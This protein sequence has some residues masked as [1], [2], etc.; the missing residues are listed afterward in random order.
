M[1]KSAIL[2]DGMNL[3]YRHYHVKKNDKN[4]Y[5]NGRFVGMFEGFL[6]TLKF[7][8]KRHHGYEIYVLWDSKTRKRLV[9]HP[10]YKKK[11]FKTEEDEAEKKKERD[12][13]YRLT[14]DLK[15]ILE[16]DGVG[17]LYAEGYEADDLAGHC[18]QKFKDYK[19]VILWT[20]DRDWTQ[21]IGGNVRWVNSHANN[22]QPIDAAALEADIGYPPS[23]VTIYKA[24]K[25]DPSDNIKGVY[26]FPVKLAKL[27]ANRT[28]SVEGLFYDRSIL[29]DLPEKWRDIIKDSATEIRLNYQLVSLFSNITNAKLTVG[30]EDKKKLQEMLD[31]FGLVKVVTK[32]KL[33]DF[34]LKRRKK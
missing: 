17:Q 4:A 22:S 19:D 31:G 2:I 23:G 34:Y 7:M 13:I 10:D 3:C 8:R 18:V 14:E 32:S 12:V 11:K 21:L 29:L 15:Y 20:S 5:R 33:D 24:L 30:K 27:L 9:L 1:S 26:G 6:N 16:L 28:T 25:G